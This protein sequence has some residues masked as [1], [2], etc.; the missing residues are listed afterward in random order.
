MMK[1]N[2]VPGQFSLFPSLI[3]GRYT[4]LSNHSQPVISRECLDNPSSA[5]YPEETGNGRDDH[6]GVGDRSDLL[7]TVLGCHI[8][9]WLFYFPS[10]QEKR[11]LKEWNAVRCHE[12]SDST[13]MEQHGE[14]R[15]QGFP[16]RRARQ[17]PCIYQDTGHQGSIV[18]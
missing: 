18:G 8:A 7:S 6:K 14:G 17:G 5:V 12:R 16:W 2:C 13:L 15:G 1:R 9:R 11:G 3:L 10:D 4:Y